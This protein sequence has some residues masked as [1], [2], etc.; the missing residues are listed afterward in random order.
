MKVLLTVVVQLVFIVSLLGQKNVLIEKFTNIYCGS[1]PNAHLIIHDYLDQYPNAIWVNHHKPIDFDFNPLVNE[2]SVTLW[3]DFNVAGVPTAMID[4]VASGNSVARGSS[5]WGGLIESQNQKEAIANIEIKNVTFDLE[6]RTFDFDVNATFSQIPASG[7]YR[8]SV[9]MVEDGVKKKQHSY[10]NDVA[11]HPLEGRGDIIWDYAHT[12]VV[13][14]ILD[15]AWGSDDVIPAIPEVGESYSKGYSYTVPDEY[16]AY[17]FLIVAMVS[18]YGQND[19]TDAEVL[20]AAQVDTRELDLILSANKEV[21]KEEMILALNPNPSSDRLN[22]Q[23]ATTPQSITIISES[24]QQIDTFQPN[25]SELNLDI[26]AY[27]AGGYY[28]IVLID[29][30]QYAET[31]VIIR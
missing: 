5:S 24:G 16:K 14:T 27:Q 29:G 20:N 4:R 9:M 30:K 17:K 22:V 25:T 12:N 10:Y 26:R 13:R 3:E 23:F 19:I 7:D 1:C 31:F 2:Q 18:K 15:D 11:G 6:S 21:R 28:L 8:L